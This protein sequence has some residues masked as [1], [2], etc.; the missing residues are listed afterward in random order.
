MVAA[1]GG[2]PNISES[3]LPSTA[4]AVAFLENSMHIQIIQN[5]FCGLDV[6][7]SEDQTQIVA[8]RFSH[9]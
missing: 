9:P 1:L 2:A 6:K 7:R 5:A 3:D 8:H 4:R